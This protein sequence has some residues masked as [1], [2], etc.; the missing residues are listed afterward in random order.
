MTLVK[1]VVSHK[2]YKSQPFSLCL[3][4]RYST[5]IYNNKLH[6]MDNSTILKEIQTIQKEGFLEKR[7]RILKSWRK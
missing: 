5:A 7:S 3:A 6:E 2:H 1:W 4:F